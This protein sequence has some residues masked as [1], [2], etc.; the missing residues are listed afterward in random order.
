[1]RVIAQLFKA[2]ALAEVKEA[3]TDGTDANKP[4]VMVVDDDTDISYYLNTILSPHYRI[5]NF[6]SAEAAK[7][8]LDTKMPD[9]ILS[10]VVME[11]KNGLELCQEIKDSAAYCH[12][13]VV[14]LTA[15]DGKYNVS[16]VSDMT[17]FNSL[18]HFSKVFK[19]KFG[20]SPRDYKG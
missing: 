3:A 2:R 5:H 13:P 6:F 4:L 8:S 11:G 7:E 14:L 17:G 16:E 18:A 1:V 9:I 10:D 15:K 12:I 20:V 19:K